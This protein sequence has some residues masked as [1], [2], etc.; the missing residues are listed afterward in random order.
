MHYL[1]KNVSNLIGIT[2]LCEHSPYFKG[3]IIDAPQV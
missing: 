1:N 2:T 3:I